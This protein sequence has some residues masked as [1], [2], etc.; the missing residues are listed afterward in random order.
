MNLSPEFIHIITNVFG[1]DGESFITNLPTLI[2]ETSQR[3]GLTNV[4]P[5]EN[6]SYN[7][8]AYAN[9]GTEKVILKMGVPNHEFKSEIPTMNSRAK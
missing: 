9:R 5:V 3:W 6:L 8:V 1:P 7:F 2:D 4:E